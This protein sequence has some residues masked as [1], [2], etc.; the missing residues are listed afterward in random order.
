MTTTQLTLND[1]T[2]AFFDNEN[3]QIWDLILDNKIDELLAIL[4]REEE[5]DD[6]FDK[7]VGELFSTEAS[8]TLAS[9]NFVK[10]KE[11]NSLLARNLA[12]LIIALDINGNYEEIRKIVAAAILEP[13]PQIV[14]NIQ[15]QSKNYP[16]GAMNTLVWAEGAG[17][18][19]ALN[20]L[21]YYYSRKENVTETLHFVTMLRTQITLAVMG[22]YKHIVGP[23]MIEAARIKEK[24]GDNESALSFYGAVDADFK[25]EFNWFLQNPEMGASEE[26]AISLHSL[27]EALTSIDRLKGKDEFGSTCIRIDE[28]LS[29]ERFEE[30]DFD[31]EDDE[32]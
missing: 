27:K 9:Y 31:E 23:D 18:R 25:S 10:I 12:R 32:D 14:D 7:I 8:E 29:R 5:E 11:P 16:K 24:I 6:T 2:K 15:E 17:M 1:E 21:V 4:P 20:G 26:E 22:H 28:I 3:K 13:M 30:P 19:A